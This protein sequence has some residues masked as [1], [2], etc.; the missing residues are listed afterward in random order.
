MSKLLSILW[1]ACL[2]AG[3]I[4]NAKADDDKPDYHAAIHDVTIQFF[5]AFTNSIFVRKPTSA[6]MLQD[7]NAG[8][9][10]RM[11]RD[12]SNRKFAGL[13]ASVDTSKCPD[14]FKSA[15]RAFVT[16]LTLND[17]ATLTDIA[18]TLK[19]LNP[20]HGAAA[21]GDLAKMADKKT[22]VKEERA[23][24]WLQLRLCA[25]SYGITNWFP[26]RKLSEP[27]QPTMQVGVQVK[28]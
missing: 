27:K 18:T 16:D 9:A 26:I 5:S 21:A 7:K 4:F 12:L 10:P 15:W 24:A 11:R 1:A 25:S 20:T 14:D 28:Q 8:V 17:K 13:L 22:E 3:F 23:G 19:D 6:E 2:A